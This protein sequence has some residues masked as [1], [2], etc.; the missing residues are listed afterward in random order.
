MITSY[1]GS[2]E[3]AKAFYVEPSYETKAEF[4]AS[5]REN[6]K[7][8][9]KATVRIANANSG[10]YKTHL[11]VSPKVTTF[12][13]TE[14]GAFDY[15]FLLGV[16]AYWNL[17]DGLDLSTRYNI[18][19]SYSDELDPVSG[20]FGASYSDGGWHSAM[21]NYTMN[22]AGGLNTVSAGLY[23]YDYVGVMDQ[24]IY[25]YD[26][27][28][29]KVKLGYFE[30]KDYSDA[31]REV[32]LAK[33]TYNYAPL[34]LYLEVQ[35]GQYWYQDTGFGLGVKRFFE[36]VAVSVNYLQTSPDREWRFSEST[37]KYIGLAIALPLDFRKSKSSGKYL[38]VQGDNSWRYEQ[39]TTV[40]RADGSNTIVPFSGYD[41]IMDFES[42]KY[43]MNRNRMNVEYVKDNAER[44]LDTF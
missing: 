41:P 37:N 14:V 10:R 3:K 32:Y 42:E 12:V 31:D 7:L 1:I 18:P 39:R 2:L 6:K 30:H 38:Q 16:T 44:L 20:V 34:D 4:T 23:D 40:A 28:T 21:L 26:R 24:F 9:E 5:L 19:I 35:G 11:V 13:G 22:I 15:Q 27:H 17:Y 36:D 43:L 33:Y 29:V 8:S 25:N